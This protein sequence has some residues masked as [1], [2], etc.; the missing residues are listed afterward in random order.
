[1]RESGTTLVE[2]IIALALISVVF[3]AAGPLIVQSLHV[4]GSAGRTLTDPD[5]VLLEAW[6]RHDVHSARAVISPL[7]AGGGPVSLDLAMQNGE[8][9][10]YMLDGSALIRMTYA[11]DG[12]VLRRHL[13]VRRVKAWAWSAF[14][15]CIMVEV[16]LPFSKGFSRAALDVRPAQLKQTTVEGRS[17]FFSLRGSGSGSW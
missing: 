9:I 12:T 10:S 14:L 1:M 17:F 15:G 11:A 3:L 2:L 13:V 8:K 5:T 16:E 4:F 7:P 6:L